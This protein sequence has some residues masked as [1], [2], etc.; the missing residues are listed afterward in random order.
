MAATAHAK[1]IFRGTV[2]DVFRKLREPVV[3][4]EMNRPILEDMDIVV[5]VAFGP[6]RRVAHY[7]A[8]ARPRKID[9]I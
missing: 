5:D 4:Y 6:H 8:P 1:S 9:A 7:G 3:R 2:S